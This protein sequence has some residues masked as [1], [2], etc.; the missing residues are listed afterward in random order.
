MVFKV[1]EDSL[2]LL[3]IPQNTLTEIPGYGTE[4]IGDAITLG[5]SELTRR[6][7]ARLTGTEVQHYLVIS[8]EGVKEITDRMGGVRVDVPNLVS[9]RATPGG[10]EITLRPGPQTLDGDQALVY[11]QG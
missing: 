3:S 5:G 10:P 9:G 2:G 4:E 11:L 6:T 7:V 1:A 8:A